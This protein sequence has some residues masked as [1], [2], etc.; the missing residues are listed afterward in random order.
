MGT[1]FIEI[2]I[3]REAH[4]WSSQKLQ[5]LLP[6]EHNHTFFLPLSI[7]KLKIVPFL[8]FFMGIVP[9]LL[10]C[11]IVVKLFFLRVFNV[12]P[13]SDVNRQESQSISASLSLRTL[14]WVMFHYDFCFSFQSLFFWIPFLCA[15]IAL[16]CMQVAK[17]VA[18][19]MHN[20]L[21]FEHLLQVHLIPPERVHPKL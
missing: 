4:S 9:F 16:P 15:N 8:F 2:H 14:R 20:Y 7:C 1:P 18:E 3:A 17:I 13:S 10:S 6:P 21:L 11:S 5:C 19:T 12:F